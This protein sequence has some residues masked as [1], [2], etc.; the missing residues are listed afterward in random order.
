MAVFLFAE[1]SA[2]A[3][4]IGFDDHTGAHNPGYQHL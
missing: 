4:P 3:P 1:K 2:D